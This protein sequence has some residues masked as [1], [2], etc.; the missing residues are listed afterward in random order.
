MEILRGV[1]D[2]SDRTLIVVTHDARILEY[3]DRIVHMDDGR[4]TGK[5]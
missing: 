5:P 1:A 2:H 4:I 3:A